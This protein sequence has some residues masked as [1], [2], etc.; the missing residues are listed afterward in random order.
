MTAPNNLFARWIS[1][2]QSY[3]FDVIH[4]PG[5]LHGNA[6]YMSRYPVQDDLMAVID[7]RDA[8]L[9]DTYSGAW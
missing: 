2:I 6:D 9:E 1:E 4:R 8:Q 5:K 3:D 7:L